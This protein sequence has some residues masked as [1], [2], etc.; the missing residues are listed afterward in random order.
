MARAMWEKLEHPPQTV[1]G[2]AAWATAITTRATSSTSGS[3]G[4]SR[5][6]VG[7]GIGSPC[8]TI[9]A[10]WPTRASRPR[11]SVSATESPALTQ[12]G[13]SGK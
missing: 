13:K 9:T 11:R 2:G 5:G 7:S 8:A 6:G 3:G 10:T 1:Q 4:T 12:P